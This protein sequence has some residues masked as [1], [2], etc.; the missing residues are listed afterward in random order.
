MNIRDE[1][2]RILSLQKS[3]LL[4]VELLEVGFVEM[5]KISMSLFESLHLFISCLQV[6]HLALLG[7][8]LFDAHSILIS[9]A[10]RLQ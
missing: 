4:V 8:E 7:N 3:H 9:E 6:F 5:L 2:V 10:D 1:V